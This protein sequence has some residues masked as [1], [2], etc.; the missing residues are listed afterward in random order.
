MCDSGGPAENRMDL[1]Y[2]I[3]HGRRMVHPI[4]VIVCT[5]NRADLLTR[6]IDQLRSQDYPE[7]SFEILVVDN[8][9]TDR[10]PI[11][12]ERLM[13]GAGVPVRYIAESRPGITF[14]RNR[15]A[16]EARYPFLA[17]LDDDCSVESDWLSQLVQGFD[18]HSDVVVVGGRVLL[19][20]DQ[21]ETSD[22][23]GPELEHW[24]AAYSHSGT[25]PQILERKARIIE[26][27]MAVK[28]EAWKAAGGF[29]G[30]EQFG[31]KHIAAS[32][33]LYLLKQIERQKG[34][35]AYVPGAVV[36]HHIGKR[37]W[38]WMLGR[39]YW[40]GVSDGILDY[41]IYRRSW[42]SIASRLILDAA[43]IVVLIGYTCFSYFK[44]DQP[45]GM[46]YLMRAIRR[47]SLIMSGIRLLGDWPRVRLWASTH[48]PAR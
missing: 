12:V 13:T 37:S 30:M 43:A 21:Q 25:Q 19:D 20:W 16:E 39:A 10:T 48:P 7:T 32:E 14:A 35:V 15:G 5:H 4:S 3:V 8:G 26:C 31:S 45:K 18:L 46:S 44:A 47:L 29:L 27:N 1:E 28:R 23:F 36:Y 9:S 34:K 33:V 11:V 17:Y 6:V 24:L 22:W 2:R 42:P 40:Q 41:L 38:R